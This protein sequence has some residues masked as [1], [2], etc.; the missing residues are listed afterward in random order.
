MGNNKLIAFFAA[1]ACVYPLFAGD[2]GGLRPYIDAALG[3]D[4]SGR[5]AQSELLEAEAEARAAKAQRLLDGSLGAAAS[6]TVTN[7]LSSSGATDVGYLGGSAS[8]QTIGPWGSVLSGS[9][10]YG[11][12]NSANAWFDGFDASLGLSIPVFVNGR[13]FDERLGAAARRAAIELPLEAAREGGRTARLNTVRSAARAAL[14]LAA[15]ERQLRL[16]SAQYKI[17]LRDAEIARVKYDAG[18]LSFRERSELERVAD[19]SGVAEISARFKRDGALGKLSRLTGIPQAEI[20]TAIQAAAPTAPSLPAEAAIQRLIEQAALAS[21]SAEV[22]SAQR[23][24]QAAR[25][26]EI[27]AGAEAAPLLSAKGSASLPGPVARADASSAEPGWSASLSLSVPLP[28]SLSKEKTAAARAKASAAGYALAEAEDS[29]QAS[30]ESARVALREAQARETYLLGLLAS[31][32]KQEGEMAAAVAAQ[33]ATALDAERADCSTLEA[34]A[35]LQD[36]R[37]A[38]FLAL[39]DIYALAGLD[40]MELVS[41]ESAPKE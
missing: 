13:F 2:S 22:R 21:G 35:S 39:M 28:L 9:L 5:R 26:A 23:Q 3:N 1:A 32:Q 33:T 38:E 8:A 30:L 12:Y 10:G 11:V 4:P 40:P 17:A 24:L 6:K 20:Q 29:A 16:A 34:S 27:L 31:A 25:D 14:D 36:A 19:S 41:A 18:T 15:A 7:E 37:S